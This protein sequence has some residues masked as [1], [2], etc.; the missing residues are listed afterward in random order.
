MWTKDCFE[1][2]DALGDGAGDGDGG[3]GVALERENV[4]ADGDL[5]LLLV[6]RHD[7]VVAAD[8]AERSTRGGLAVEGELAAR[9]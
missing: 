8:D 4:F 3:R 2:V 9:D 1:R 5:D 6:P 7:L